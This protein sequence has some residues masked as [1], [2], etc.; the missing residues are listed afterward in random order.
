MKE[1]LKDPR[2]DPSALEGRGFRAAAQY[3]HADVILELLKDLRVD[4]SGN[5]AFVILC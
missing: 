2:V 3:G 5:N 1:L 4:P